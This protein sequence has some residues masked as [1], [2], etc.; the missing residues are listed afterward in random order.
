MKQPQG[1][2]NKIK[3]HYICKLDKKSERER[4]VVAI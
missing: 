3:S 4:R 2:E 1:Y